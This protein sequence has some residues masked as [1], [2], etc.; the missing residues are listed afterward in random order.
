MPCV[1]AKMPDA[2]YLELKSV[3][4]SAYA[5]K[6][7]AV[8]P[9][10][11]IFGDDFVHAAAVCVCVRVCVCVCLR[12]E[13]WLWGS[14]WERA[15]VPGHQAFNSKTFQRLSITNLMTS[16]DRAWILAFSHRRHQQP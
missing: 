13:S 7:M 12:T 11:H 16:A 15:G 8:Q 2:L 1:C 14:T 5:M 3:F 10:E 6:R 4:V 9:T